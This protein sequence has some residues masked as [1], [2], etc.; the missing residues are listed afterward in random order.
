M[1]DFIS[2][3]DFNKG[4]DNFLSSV[5]NVINS[6][7][8]LLRIPIENTL[9]DLREFLSAFIKSK[10]FK[11]LMLEQDIIRKWFL[12]QCHNSLDKGLE[13]FRT[14]EFYKVN[15]QLTI[16]ELRF[17]EFNSHLFY[18]LTNDKSIHKRQLSHEN[19]KFIICDCFKA[20]FGEEYIAQKMDEWRFF[21]IK[22][23]FLNI[24]FIINQETGEQEGNPSFCYF[25]E[26]G[27]DSCTVLYN[28]KILYML[29]TNGMT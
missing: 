12:Y 25:D 10:D 29:F 21:S 15:F 28:S 9:V 27:F 2:Q 5:D 24:T 13:E 14:G 3:A 6:N 17:E 8:F 20:I 11:Q 26:Y 22:P 18:L 1:D 7:T 4:I 19:A 16:T 23:D